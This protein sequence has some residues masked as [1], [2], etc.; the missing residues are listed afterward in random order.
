MQIRFRAVQLERMSPEPTNHC[1]V[2]DVPQVTQLLI[3]GSKRG[4]SAEYYPLS[5]L[6]LT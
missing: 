6:K 3:L 5:Y 1:C 2:F 4:A